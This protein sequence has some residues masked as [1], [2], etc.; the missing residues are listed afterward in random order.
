M[1]TPVLAEPQVATVWVFVF[2]MNRSTKKRRLVPTY[3]CVT[4]SWTRVH[5]C[6]PIVETNPIHGCVKLNLR[7]GR[8]DGRT[9]SVRPPL[10]LKTHGVENWHRFS[11]S[12]IGTDFRNVGHAKMTPIFDSE[13]RRRFSTP[14]RT[15]SIS[16]SIFGS[17]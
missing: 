4:Q 9:V 10:R 3:V 17:T 12:K 7:D 5:F 1:G 6:R 15:C 8:T 2:Q 16:R 13:N 14:I 11:E